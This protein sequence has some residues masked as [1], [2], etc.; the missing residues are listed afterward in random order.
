MTQI[1]LHRIASLALN[2]GH[3]YQQT[4]K[5]EDGETVRMQAVGE[6]D[7]DGTLRFDIELSFQGEKIGDASLDVFPSREGYS[8]EPYAHIHPSILSE[9]QGRGI[10]TQLYEFAAEVAGLYDAVLTASDSLSDSAWSL[11]EKLEDQGISTGWTID[12]RSKTASAFFQE[13]LYRGEGGKTWPAQFAVGEHWSTQREV[14][15]TYGPNVREEV[16]SLRNP[17][18]WKLPGKRPYYEELQTAFGTSDPTRITSQL[19]ED[20]YDGLIV[21]NVPVTRGGTYIPDSTEVIVF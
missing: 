8:Q 10:G 19:K 5:T 16:V 18:V 15:E 6:E 2:R 12:K 14:A 13:K 11:W 4:V 1:N 7:T 20:G 17:L 3:R 21:H 9:F